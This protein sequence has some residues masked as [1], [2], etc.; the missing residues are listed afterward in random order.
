[1]VVGSEVVD[2]AV[3]VVGG[4]GGVVV[5]PVTGVVVVVAGVVVVGVAVIVAMIAGVVLVN[6][7]LVCWLRVEPP[8]KTVDLPLHADNANADAS[9]AALR[10]RMREDRI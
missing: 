9:A 6:T 4:D 8:L 2:V 10:T 7:V 1:V 3:F 5:V